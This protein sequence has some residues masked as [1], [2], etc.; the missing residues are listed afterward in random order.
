[1]A[2]GSMTVPLLSVNAPTSPHYAES[3]RRYQRHT[4]GR[5]GGAGIIHDAEMLLDACS[6]A[7]TT[8]IA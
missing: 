2:I 8:A 6:L 7:L 1:M 4:G 5:T 3:W